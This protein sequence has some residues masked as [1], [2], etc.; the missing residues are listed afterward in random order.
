VYYT[1]N[2]QE[3]ELSEGDKW[4]NGV[5]LLIHLWPS[6]VAHP[7]NPSYSGGEDQEDLGLWSMLSEKLLRPLSQK[8]SWI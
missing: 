2:L 8:I 4:T 5:A 6:T 3:K 7:Y 1:D